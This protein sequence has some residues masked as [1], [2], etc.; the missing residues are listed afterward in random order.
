MRYLP[1]EVLLGI[2]SR[3]LTMRAA[4]APGP[5]SRTDFRALSVLC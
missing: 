2:K 5:G 3:R 1:R 4:D